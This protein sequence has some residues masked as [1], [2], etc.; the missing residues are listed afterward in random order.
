[1][2]RRWNMLNPWYLMLKEKSSK[3]ECKFCG[4]VISYHKDRML[5]HLGDDMMAM[6]SWNYNVFRGTSTSEGFICPMWWI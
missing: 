4:N 2:E 1:M 5:F 3:V 6:G